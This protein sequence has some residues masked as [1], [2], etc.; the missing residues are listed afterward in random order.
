MRT[1][2][3]E[4]AKERAYGLEDETKNACGS[5]DRRDR[6]RAAMRDAC[7]GRGEVLAFAFAKHRASYEAHET[8]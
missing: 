6:W 4:I 2:D 5:K 8:E 3:C 1:T 7:L